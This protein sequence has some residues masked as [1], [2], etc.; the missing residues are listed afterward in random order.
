MVHFTCKSI[1]Q[2]FEEYVGVK[3]WK[4][5]YKIV[6]YFWS[7][8]PAHSSVV[9]LNNFSSLLLSQYPSALH[10]GRNSWTR[11]S[12]SFCSEIY[13]FYFW[14]KKDDHFDNKDTSEKWE[15]KRQKR[16]RIHLPFLFFFLPTSLCYEND[17][18]SGSK[19]K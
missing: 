6:I 12:T 8:S 15:V 10:S 11:P 4:N 3:T 7:S 1:E 13:L 2:I 18:I 16:Q 17:R 5:F 14:D 9:V 19:K